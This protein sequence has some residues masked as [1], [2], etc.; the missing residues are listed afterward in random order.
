MLTVLMSL[1]ISRLS[2]KTPPPSPPGNCCWSGSLPSTVFKSSL[3]FGCTTSGAVF[4]FFLFSVRSPL[5][6]AAG[7]HN[8]VQNEIFSVLTESYVVFQ[9]FSAVPS[10]DLPC[11]VVGWRGAGELDGLAV[12]RGVSEEVT[13]IFKQ[14]QELVG[15]VLK[16]GQHLCRHHVVHNEERRLSDKEEQGVKVWR[17]KVQTTSFVV[18]SSLKRY[19]VITNHDTIHTGPS[20]VINQGQ[21]IQCLL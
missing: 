11:V 4:S 10:L 20:I 21:S 16:D 1:S 9:F 18:S 6:P 12:Q 8:Y 19:F 13:E 15:G 17:K 5:N 2:P 14:L 7:Q 3:T